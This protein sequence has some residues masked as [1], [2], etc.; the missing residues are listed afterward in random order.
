MHHAAVVAE[1]QAGQQIFH[2]P[3][4]VGDGEA[5]LLVHQ[6]LQR[7]AVDIFHHDIG[8]IAGFAVIEDA[9][10]IGMGQTAGSLRLPPEAGERFLGFGIGGVRQVDGFD[11]HLP[12]D[13]RVPAFID[14]SHRT[15]PELALDLVLAEGLDRRHAAPCTLTLRAS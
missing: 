8:D 10:D 7:R 9:D 2:D 14:R 11:R 4:R 15:A 13:D 3:Q 1:F 6:V 12:F 5:F